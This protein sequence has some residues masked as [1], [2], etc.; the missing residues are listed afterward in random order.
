MNHSDK[1]FNLFNQF[2][3]VLV[4]DKV[5][6]CFSERGYATKPTGVDYAQMRFRYNEE[7]TVESMVKGRPFTRLTEVSWMVH[8]SVQKESAKTRYYIVM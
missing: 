1:V 4:I 8:G 3:N 5:L 6:G 2:G 7:L